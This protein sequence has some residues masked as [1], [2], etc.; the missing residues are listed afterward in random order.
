MDIKLTAADLVVPVIKKELFK[1]EVEESKAAAK[2]VMK[3][4]VFK[5]EVTEENVDDGEQ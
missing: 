3:Q 4:E 1:S 2:L 5:H